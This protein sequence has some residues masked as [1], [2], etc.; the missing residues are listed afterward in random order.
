MTEYD[1]FIAGFQY[2]DA[3][4]VRQ[5]IMAQ[6]GLAPTFS[7]IDT[8]SDTVGG[9]DGFDITIFFTAPLSGPSQTLLAGLMSTYMTSVPVAKMK[10]LALLSLTAQNFIELKYPLLT[11]IQL[12]N[13]YTLAKFDGLINRAAYIR[14]GIDWINSISVYALSASVAI[15]ALTV[16]ADVNNYTID[17]ASNIGTDP[18]LTISA[19]LSIVN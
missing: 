19:A 4:Y 18:L 17:V 14:P 2:T 12:I 7:T 8:S 3:E 13:L 5:L 10:K 15:Q 6:S 1:F 16:F 11:R 9:I